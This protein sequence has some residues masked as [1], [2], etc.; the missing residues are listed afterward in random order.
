M[1]KSSVKFSQ[2]WFLFTDSTTPK[3]AR[4][5]GLSR[6]AP[7]LGH[8]KKRHQTPRV[9][10]VLLMASRG[11]QPAPA[12]I[13][14]LSRTSERVFLKAIWLETRPRIPSTPRKG[15]F[16]TWVGWKDSPRRH[17]RSTRWGALGT[18]KTSTNL[19]G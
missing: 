11:R 18:L 8:L 10:K 9:L 15:K 3:T 7:R 16:W 4:A 14:T 5:R 19:I 6:K 17:Q 13:Q 1:N 2:P 12:R